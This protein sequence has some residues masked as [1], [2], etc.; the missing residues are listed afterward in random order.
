MIHVANIKTFRSGE[1]SG[2]SEYIGRAMPGRPGSPLGNPFKLRFEAQ[3]AEILAK[4]EAW[5]REQMKT[6]TAARREIKRL[7]DLAR[8]QDLVLLCW[9]APALCHGDV[10]KRII[11]ERY[12]QT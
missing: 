8:D 12:G 10:I 11:E 6:D 9:C 7:A 5:L 4:Y 3:R 2:R 1:R